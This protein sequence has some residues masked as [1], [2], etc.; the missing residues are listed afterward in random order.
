MH[1]VIPSKSN[2]Q[3][4][5]HVDCAVYRDRNRVER[6]VNPSKDYR[7]PATRYEKL[8]IVY[9]AMVTIAAILVRR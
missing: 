6:C 9:L 5:R 4:Q 1:P 3:S 7:C 2:E 8:A